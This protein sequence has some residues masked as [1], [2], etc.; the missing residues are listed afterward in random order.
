MDVRPS[1]PDAQKKKWSPKPFRRLVKSL[2]PHASRASRDSKLHGPRHWERVAR[3]GAYLCDVTEER[4][5]A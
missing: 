4:E 1:Q 5:G 3:T 2:L